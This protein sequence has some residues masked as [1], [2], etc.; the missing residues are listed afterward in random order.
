MK[1]LWAH[2][3][4]DTTNGGDVPSQRNLTRHGKTTEDG[5]VAKETDEGTDHRNTRTGTVLL[6]GSR[7]KVDVN[8]DVLEY[9]LGARRR[10]SQFVRVRLDP[11]KCEVGGLGDDLAQLTREF[12]PSRTRHARRFDVCDGRQSADLRT[13]RQDSRRIPP[14]PDPWYAS[15]VETPTSPSF[16]ISSTSY[17]TPPRMTSKS[18]F[19]TSFL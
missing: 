14:L 5:H 2:L 7:R 3:L 1:G 18:S 6:D 10:D 11:C 13:S 16:S 17:R 4:L 9:V 15:P 19:V 8:V 12:E